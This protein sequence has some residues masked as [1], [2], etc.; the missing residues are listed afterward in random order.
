MDKLLKYFSTLTLVERE[1][2]ISLLKL[3]TETGFTVNAIRK[4]ASNG[5][6]LPPAVCSFFEEHTNGQVTRK[7]LRPN[8]WHLIWLELKE[9]AA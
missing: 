5:Q 7:D 4:Y 8:D 3:R 9:G 1:N 6:V 2:L